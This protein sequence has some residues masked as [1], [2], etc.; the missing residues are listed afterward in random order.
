MGFERTSPFDAHAVGTVSVVFHF[1]AAWTEGLSQFID[2][3]V[4]ISEVSGVFGIEVDKGFN[5][6]LV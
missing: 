6:P 2:R 3:V 4:F 5:V 1:K